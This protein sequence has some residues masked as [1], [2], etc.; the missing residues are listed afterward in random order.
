MRNTFAFAVLLIVLPA[1]RGKT[2][3]S[4]PAPASDLVAP[5]VIAGES[6]QPAPGRDPRGYLHCAISGRFSGVAYARGPQLELVVTS[7]AIAVTRTEDKKFGDDLHVRFMLGRSRPAPGMM[8]QATSESV[9]VRLS[10]TV[11]TSAAL[12]T[13][14]QAQDTMHLLL[15]WDPNGT[16]RRI[17]ASVGYRARALDGLTS[18]CGMFI[19]GD[20]L[21]FSGSTKR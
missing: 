5:F 15:P 12:L 8:P 14:W 20:T 18:D 4:A 11:D 6:G 13:T 9:E 21:R 16:P 10:P 2:P 17:F 7:G 1:C 19:P 3:E